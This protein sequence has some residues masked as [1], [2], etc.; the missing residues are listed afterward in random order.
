MLGD[1]R[2]FEMPLRYPYEAYIQP[3]PVSIAGTQ[4]FRSLPPTGERYVGLTAPIPCFFALFVVLPLLAAIRER[5]RRL[6]R[7]IGLCPTCGYDL[8]ATPDRCPECGTIPSSV[9]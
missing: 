9:K 3:P 1:F 7:R 6:S 4:L 8:R 2:H 5:R